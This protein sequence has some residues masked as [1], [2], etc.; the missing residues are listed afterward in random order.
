MKMTDQNASRGCLVGSRQTYD[1]T[2]AWG[3]AENG[4]GRQGKSL[5]HRERSS[6]RERRWVRIVSNLLARSIQAQ[7]DLSPIDEAP[8]RRYATVAIMQCGGRMKPIR[9]SDAGESH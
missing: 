6:P 7:L 2:S 8:A 3:Y 1:F 5:I 4:S 9:V